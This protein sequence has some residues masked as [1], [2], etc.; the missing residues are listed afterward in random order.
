MEAIVKRF[1]EQLEQLRVYDHA[2]GILYYDMET[3]M[4]KGAFA[5]AGD[6]LGA[7]SEVSYKLRTDETF[8]SD[9]QAI[10][11]NPDQV[12]PITLCEAKRMNED[13]ERIACIPIEEY[14]AYQV[15]STAA[16]SAWQE[17]KAKNE[18]ALF[19]PHLEKLIDYTRRFALYYKPDAPVYDTLLD[20]YEK[21]LTTEMLDGFFRDVR[22]ALVPLIDRIRKNGYQPDTSFLEQRYPIEKQRELTK[23]LMQVMCMDPDHS[24]CGEVEHPFTTNFT[25][26]DVRITTHYYEDAVQSSMYSVIHEAGHATYELNVGDE[27]ARSPLGTGVS[28]GV[29]ESQSRFF[30]NIIGRSEPFIEAVYPKLTE[31]FPEQLKGVSAHAFYLA[32]NKAEPSLIRTEADELT[33]SLHIMVR[34]ELEKQLI[35]G[36]LKAADL[37]KAWNAMYREYLGIDVPNDTMG[38]L[39]DSHWSGGSFGYFPSYAIGSAYG[40]Q[41]LKRMER[42]LDVW[43]LAKAGNLAP[44]IAWLKERIYQYGCRLDPKELMEQAFEAPFDPNYYIEYLTEKFTELYRL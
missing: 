26:A 20:E 43:G 11:A 28:M 44:I 6:T 10:L 40:A 13:R 27:I 37:P 2:M 31:L 16:F 39:Q 33:Y 34:Y 21:G 15:E 8:V 22:S 42:D 24:T 32:V 5:L 30:E 7:L 18:F 19:L 4:P 14:V 41:L 23:T 12:D 36:T 1:K 29:H 3:V 25:K 35:A 38:V 9:M 17:A